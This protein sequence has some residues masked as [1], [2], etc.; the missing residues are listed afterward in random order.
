MEPAYLSHLAVSTEFNLIHSI[1]LM[2]DI[3]FPIH[4]EQ[5]NRAF[6]IYDLMILILMSADLR[7]PQDRCFLHSF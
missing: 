2:P 1:F 6:E 5:G 4:S 3:P 7:L